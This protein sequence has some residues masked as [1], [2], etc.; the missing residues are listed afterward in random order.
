MKNLL[1]IILLFSICACRKN[2]EVYPTKQYEQ[3]EFSGIANIGSYR[4]FTKTGEVN[5]T[6]LVS[7]YAGEYSRYFYGGSVIFS[8]PEFRSFSF[9]NED[10]VINTGIN[11]VGELKRTL[12][13]DYDV[14][15]SKFTVPVNDTNNLNLHLGKYKLYNR[16]T[17]PLGYTYFELNDPATIMKRVNDKL[18]LPIVRYIITSTGTNSFSFIA[19]RFNNVFD[20]TGI[21]KLGNQDTLLIQTFDVELKKQ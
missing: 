16:A 13:S 14:F 3:F 18:Y 2:P 9:V 20:P 12:R 8:A 19:D 1:A 5:N 15:T 17:T 4:M 10:S 7:K 21:S 11:P 6:M